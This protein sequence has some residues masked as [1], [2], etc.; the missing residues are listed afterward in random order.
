MNK[1][2]LVEDND[3]ITMGLEFLLK[4]EGYLFEAAKNIGEAG[5]KMARERF[6]LVLLDISLPGWEW[7]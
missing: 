1:I 2:L 6:D 7:I 3:A 5:E 4:E